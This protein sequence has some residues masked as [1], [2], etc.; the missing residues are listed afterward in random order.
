MVLCRSDVRA[1]QAYW[2]PSTRRRAAQ[3]HSHRC[4]SPRLRHGG[5]SDDLDVRRGW[6]SCSI[7][8]QAGCARLL[9]S[10]SITPLCAWLSFTW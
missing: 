7:S 9:D 10:L 6:I 3:H 5:A 8:S 4:L 2:R 1:A